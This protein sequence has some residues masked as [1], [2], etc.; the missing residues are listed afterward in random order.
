MATPDAQ[1]HLFSEQHYYFRAQFSSNNSTNS[2]S[3]VMEELDQLATTPAPMLP[4]SGFECSN[5]SRARSSTPSN[6]WL[7]RFKEHCSFQLPA[8][9]TEDKNPSSGSTS[10]YCS[11]AA[12]GV[13]LEDE[14]RK[15]QQYDLA[16]VPELLPP[17]LLPPSSSS[18]A[19][20]STSHPVF[21][22][23][24][25]PAFVRNVSTTAPDPAK[26]SNLATFSLYSGTNTVE[27]E[28]RFRSCSEG[29]KFTGA[30]A[31]SSCV[32]QSDQPLLQNCT[33]QLRGLQEELVE[34]KNKVRLPIPARVS[35]LGGATPAPVDYSADSAIIPVLVLPPQAAAP[36]HEEDPFPLGGQEV[37]DHADLEDDTMSRQHAGARLG[38]EESLLH[39]SNPSSVLDG[40]SRKAASPLSDVLARSV[41]LLST[42]R[43]DAQPQQGE[44]ATNSLLLTG[45]TR[46]PER[47]VEV[48]NGTNIAEDD[49]RHQG[50]WC[51]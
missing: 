29:T 18:V 43:K 6:L 20:S 24:M 16:S 3:M 7:R 25:H 46:S 35:R 36:A 19:S 37:H 42:T 8:V 31:A 2:T 21:D 44:G 15:G 47:L 30:V 5:R 4:P 33:T 12:G 34:I 32:Q 9:L 50:S 40:E 39:T 22:S 41:A 28:N 45:T 38:L 14:R 51:S 48:K 27:S 23:D 13:E 17:E 49:E 26:A 11:V 1:E 10:C